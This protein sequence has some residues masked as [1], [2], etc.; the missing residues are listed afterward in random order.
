MMVLV[1]LL[2]MA[3]FY[4]DGATLLVV[5]LFIEVFYHDGASCVVVHSGVLS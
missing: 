3:L 5:L 2:F 1:V 4:H